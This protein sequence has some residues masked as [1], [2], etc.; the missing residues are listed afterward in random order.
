MSI[1]INRAQKLAKIGDCPGSFFAMLEFIPASAIAALNS[2]QIAELI[3]AVWRL[4]SA[5][6]ALAAADAIMEGGVWDHGK[7][8]FREL[9]IGD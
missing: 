8:R 4:A 3:D 6:K 2:R 5:S 7:Q 1:K 9:R